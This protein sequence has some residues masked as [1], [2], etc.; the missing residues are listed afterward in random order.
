MELKD[1]KIEI[2]QTIRQKNKKYIVSKVN[3][4]TV[5]LREYRDRAIPNTTHRRVTFGD[6]FTAQIVG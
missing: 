1:K 2:G 5:T 6:F 4:K 3:A